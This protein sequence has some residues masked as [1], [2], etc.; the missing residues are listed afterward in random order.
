MSDAAQTQNAVT[1]TATQIDS[2]MAK[3][4]DMVQ[5]LGN[6]TAD[7]IAKSWDYAEVKLT[8]TVRQF[9]VWEFTSACIM[10]VITLIIMTVCWRV[11]KSQAKS[12]RSE[13]KNEYAVLDPS[14][15]FD[16][17]SFVTLAASSATRFFSS[18]I[19]AVVMCY[20]GNSFVVNIQK[21]AKIA[22]APRIYLI[23]YGVQKYKEIKTPT[24]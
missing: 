22:L 14:R 24:K 18:I 3:F 12:W 17:V 16:N 9:L 15:D 10:A 7:F 4:L 19:L 13:Y 5:S 6:R 20:A 8:E 21:S 2:G 23:E 11:G 1:T